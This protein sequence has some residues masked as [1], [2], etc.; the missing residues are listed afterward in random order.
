[1][2][3][4][5]RE[6]SFFIVAFILFSSVV[7]AENE[8]QVDITGVDNPCK[9][10]QEAFDTYL[11][12]APR[13]MIL[14]IKGRARIEFNQFNDIGEYKLCAGL[15]PGLNGT[16]T[17]ILKPDTKKIKFRGGIVFDNLFLDYDARQQDKPA[18]IFQW[19]AL[20][21]TG[22]K[23]DENMSALGDITVAGR[24]SGAISIRSLFRKVENWRAGQLPGLPFSGESMSKTTTVSWF[25]TGVNRADMMGLS[26][27]FESNIRDED[28]IGILH[29]HAW[30]VRH[31]PV[32][33]EKY[34]VGLLYYGNSVG[35]ISSSYIHRNSFGLVLGDFNI[36]GDIVPSVN[37]LSG[38]TEPSKKQA[39]CERRNHQV[40]G[41]SVYDSVIEGNTYGN[42]VI[43][44]AARIDIRSSHLE[45]PLLQYQKGHGVLIGGGICSPAGINPVCASDEDCNGGTCKYPDKTI[46]QG[47]KF[48]GGFVGGDRFSNQWDGIVIGAN[49]KQYNRKGAQ[50][51]FESYLG[52]SDTNK[53]EQ[54]LD[55]CSFPGVDCNV[56]SYRKGATINVDI[57][58]SFY[59]KNSKVTDKSK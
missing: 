59:S 22:W 28:D 34:G 39:L 19:G 46:Y 8:L 49:A 47:I 9:V 50:V 43:N 55:K 36:G 41:L 10:M 1:M 23:N 11:N 13:N 54:Q 18:V 40:I 42:V 7:S 27:D 56:I 17:Q 20:Y 52:H 45:M 48:D 44:D 26:L 4:H 24:I 58:R 53:N 32:R 2:F 31:G 33:I 12:R 35:S 29:Q 37:C 51:V 15:G 30:G 16:D 3:N 6:L 5:I 38:R 25:E 21:N 14:H 57:S